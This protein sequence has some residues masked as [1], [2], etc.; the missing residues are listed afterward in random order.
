MSRVH[1]LHIGICFLCVLILFSK[2]L[3]ILAKN[4]GQTGGQIS[5]K[6]TTFGTQ[7][8]SNNIIFFITV[9]RS[10][11]SRSFINKSFFVDHRPISA[12][13]LLIAVNEILSTCNYERRSDAWIE[14]VEIQVQSFVLFISQIEQKSSKR[15]FFQ[16]GHKGV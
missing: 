2:G 5:C 8:V 10:N 11:S 12:K 4:C 9:L 15:F 14:R 7:D 13:V 6:V 3:Q 16:G 1:L